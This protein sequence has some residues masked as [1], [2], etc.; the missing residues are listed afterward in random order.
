M[1]CGERIFTL[2]RLINLR[3]GYTKKDDI[4][5]PKMYI[6]AKKGFRAEKIPQFDD[7]LSEY[8]DLR[9]WNEKGQ[10]TTKKLRELGLKDFEKYVQV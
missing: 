4:L 9:K 8:Y 3:D 10:P 1:R 5:P 2:Q 6:P 7:L